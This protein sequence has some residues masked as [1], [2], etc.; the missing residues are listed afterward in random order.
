M[1]IINDV[2][3][4]LVH[5]Y[6]NDYPGVFKKQAGSTGLDMFFEYEYTTRMEETLEKNF[7]LDHMNI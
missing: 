6:R 4:N 5:D 1:S 2:I 7:D 3:Q